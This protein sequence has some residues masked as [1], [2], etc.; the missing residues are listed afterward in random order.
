MQ[1]SPAVIPPF[2]A[3][4][5]QP[6]M[7]QIALVNPPGSPPTGPLTGP[8]IN[9]MDANTGFSVSPLNN[10]CAA[11]AATG[12]PANNQC[13]FTVVFTSSVTNPTEVA[14]LQASAT[15]GGTATAQLTGTTQ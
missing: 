7:Q 1:F 9:T 13:L 3:G 4:A 11:I 12:L 2:V 15:P 5:G 14:T 10:E 8:L 6:A